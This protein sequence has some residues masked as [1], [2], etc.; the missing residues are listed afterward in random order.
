MVLRV[1]WGFVFTPFSSDRVSGE[2]L[3][4]NES[5]V[6]SID[7]RSQSSKPPKPKR[8]QPELFTTTGVWLGL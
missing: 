2:G 3:F 1:I 5:E 7:L 4:P 6:C 8:I